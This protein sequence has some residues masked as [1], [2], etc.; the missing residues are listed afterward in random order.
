MGILSPR[1]EEEVSIE[2]SQDSSQANKGNSLL[3][4]WGED[5]R[6]AGEGLKGS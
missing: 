3:A 6:R 4:P 5:A 1:G 2:V